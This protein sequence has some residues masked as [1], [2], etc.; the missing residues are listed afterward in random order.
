MLEL[1]NNHPCITAYV[2]ITVAA[3]IGAGWRSYLKATH[4]DWESD[5]DDDDD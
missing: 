1:I 5:I 3:I 4:G 2:V